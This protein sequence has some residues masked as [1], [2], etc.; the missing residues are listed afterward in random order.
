MPKLGSTG[1]LVQALCS[2]GPLLLLL[3]LLLRRSP[4]LGA[5]GERVV[6]KEC[7]ARRGAKTCTQIAHDCEI[8]NAD[9][10]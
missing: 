2:A 8:G 5:G 1:S 6:L 9:M 7:L 4:E 3:V 10:T